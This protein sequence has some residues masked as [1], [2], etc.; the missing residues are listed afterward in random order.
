MILPTLALL[1]ALTMSPHEFMV[2]QVATAMGVDPDYA[3]CIVA[4]ESEWDAS[5]VGDLHLGEPSVGLWQWRIE[6]WRHVRARMGLSIE[7]RRHDP[8]ASTAAAIWWI[9]QGYADWWSASNACVPGG[10]IDDHG[11]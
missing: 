1:A 3:A 4:R 6:S 10:T 9:R 7:D 8:V 11:E 2:R 5:A